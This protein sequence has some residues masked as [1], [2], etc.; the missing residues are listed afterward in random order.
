MPRISGLINKNKLRG[1]KE[2][3]HAKEKNIFYTLIY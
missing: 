3:K 1:G 2:L